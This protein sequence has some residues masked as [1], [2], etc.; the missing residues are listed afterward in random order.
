MRFLFPVILFIFIFLT[1]SSAF[2]YIID[3]RLDD[4]WEVNPAISDWTP[5]AGVFYTHE[6]YVRPSDGYVGP[7]YGGQAFD[8]E[9]LYVDWNDSTFYLALVTGW[10][11]TGYP[12]DP[13]YSPGDIAIDFGGN[14]TWDYAIEIGAHNPSYTGFSGIPGNVFTDVTWADASPYIEGSPSHILG[15]PSLKLAGSS[16]AFSYNNAHHGSEHWVVELEIDR[17]V[18]DSDWNDYMNVHWTQT[19]GNDILDVTTIPEPMSMAL[20]ASGI[21]GLAFGM[22]RKKGNFT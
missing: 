18:F 14:G 7:G 1:P 2:P 9:G 6:D 20:V 16:T 19:C 13:D 12:P 11:A 22:K 17:T 10:P 21:L 4:D 3:G 5:K 15:S 8:A